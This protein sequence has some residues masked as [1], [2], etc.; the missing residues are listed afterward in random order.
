[1]EYVTSQGTP[2]PNMKACSIPC[3]LAKATSCGPNAGCV[4]TGAS[5]TDCSAVGTAGLGEDCTNNED[6]VA[7]AACVDGYCSKWCRLPAILYPNDCASTFA[8]CMAL[9]RDVTVGGT[10]YGACL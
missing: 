2:I 7:G 1:M 6:C 8:T 5:G 3:D 9:N 10:R 4:Y